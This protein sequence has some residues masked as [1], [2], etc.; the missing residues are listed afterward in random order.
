MSIISLIFYF[1]SIQSFHKI[2][3]YILLQAGWNEIKHDNFVPKHYIILK[4]DQMVFHQ[5]WIKNQSSKMPL[6][7][8]VDVRYN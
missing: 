3:V 5:K 8:T 7:K 6:V 1:S 4:G 2:C